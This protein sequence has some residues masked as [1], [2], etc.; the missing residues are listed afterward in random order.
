[1]P[2]HTHAPR[3]GGIRRGPRRADN[4][5]ILS[6]IVLD[7]DRLSYRARGLLVWLLSKPPTGI[8]APNR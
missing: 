5:T 1:V 4:F 2:Q 8:S 3:Q 6:N 7:D